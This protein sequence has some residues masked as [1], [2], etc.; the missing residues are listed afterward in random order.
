MASIDYATRSISAKLV[1]WGAEG[2]GKTS[3]VRYVWER[4]RGTTAAW[5]GDPEVP[6][7]DSIDYLPL[8]LGEIRG[9]TTR[10]ELFAVPGAPRHEPARRAL[11]AEVDGVVLVADGR[12]G[13]HAE[14]VASLAELD[15]ALRAHG[16]ALDRLPWVIQVNKRDLADAMPTAELL[17]TLGRYAPPCIESTATT[18]EGVFEALKA[19]SKLVLMELRK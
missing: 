9:F 13:R 7:E 19:V 16:R 6:P 1:Y 17:I 2:S 14:D 5:V 11:L 8:T 3:S 10:F 4:T 18:G 12:R 15:A